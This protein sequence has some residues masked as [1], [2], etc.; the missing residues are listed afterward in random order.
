MAYIRILGFEGLLILIFQ[1][2]NLIK[3]C[4]RGEEM[5]QQLVVL[6]A[7]AEDLSSNYSTHFR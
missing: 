3:H 1:E 5:A 6:G 7:P 2:L 4:I